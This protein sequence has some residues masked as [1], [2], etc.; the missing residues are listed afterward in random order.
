L[1]F[2]LPSQQHQST[3]GSTCWPAHLVKNWWICCGELLLPR[4]L[5]FVPCAMTEYIVAMSLQVKN[6]E[7][8]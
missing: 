5:A 3:E 8:W 1:A 2:L 6:A 4:A 7:M